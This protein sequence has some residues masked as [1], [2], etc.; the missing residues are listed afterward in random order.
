MKTSKLKALLAIGMITVCVIVGSS[1]FAF[2]NNPSSANSSSK[3]EKEN[4][5]IKNDISNINLLKE[6]IKSLQEKIKA[7]LKAGLK[8][9]VVMGKRDLM[10][11]KADLEQ[12]QTYLKA[13]KM[14]IVN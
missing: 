12:Q 13:D 14:D 9:E 6:N 7:D 1:I 2:G 4:S 8:T 5:D 10:K 3:Y 11:R